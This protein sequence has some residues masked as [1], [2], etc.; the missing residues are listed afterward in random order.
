MIWIIGGTSDARKF[1]ESLDNTEDLIITVTTDFGKSLVRDASVLVGRL[2]QA[3]MENLILDREVDLIIDMSHPYAQEVSINAEN[4]AGNTNVD[5]YRYNRS[6]LK[7]DQ[8]IIAESMDELL[9]IIKDIEATILFT[10]GSKD[11]KVFESVRGNSKHIYRILPLI[12]SLKIAEDA[13]VSMK[14]L[15]CMV[16][17]A[18]LE[19]NV[20]TINF[21]KIS[22]MVLKESGENSGF[23]EKIEACRQTGVIPVILKRPENEGIESFLELKRLIEDYRKK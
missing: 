21:Y 12:D 11:I 15:I 8:G 7:S 6:S 14:N 19:L 10:T 23:D 1:I 5:Y 22:Y 4:A 9:G 3:D 2:N 17:P 16:G 13:G 18:D 20:A